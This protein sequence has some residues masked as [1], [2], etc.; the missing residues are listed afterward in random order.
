MRRGHP[1]RLAGVVL[2]AGEGR[3][4]GPRPK[5]LLPYQGEPLV[6]RAAREA[7]RA[8]LNPVGVVLGHRAED[9]VPALAGLPVRV[10]L[11][12][13]WAMGM[14]RSVRVAVRAAQ[15]WQADGLLITLADMPYVDA[16]VLRAVQQAFARTTRGIVTLDVQGQRVPPVAYHR[17]VW[18]AL[19]RLEGDTGG[20]ALFHR[21]PVHRVPWP[22]PRVA[23]DID[24]PGDWQRV[25]PI[26]AE[27]G[28]EHA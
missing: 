10:L 13:A 21:F 14:A 4:F 20:R 26:S 19:L 3:R 28:H 24:T 5:V 18:P 8:G 22:D 6:R 25:R 15:A 27:R 23:L 2:A 17:D 16:A 7:L 1:M 12:P 11:N 9:V